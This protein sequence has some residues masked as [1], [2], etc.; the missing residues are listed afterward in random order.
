MI[1]SVGA[2]VFQPEK[3]SAA[4]PFRKARITRP[5]DWRLFPLAGP[6]AM[7]AQ[8]EKLLAKSN[9]GW[10]NCPPRKSTC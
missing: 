1:R 4:S 8:E 5:L 10:R 7:V 9:P 2:K 6:G 3:F